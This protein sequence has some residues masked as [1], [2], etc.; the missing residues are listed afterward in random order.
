MLDWATVWPG[1]TIIM[2]LLGFAGIAVVIAILLAIPQLQYRR[3]PEGYFM[4]VE[5]YEQYKEKFQKN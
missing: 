3:N 4:Q 2:K 1:F 5:D